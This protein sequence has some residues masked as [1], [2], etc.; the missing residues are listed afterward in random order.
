MSVII[1][2]TGISARGSEPTPAY[3]YE[4]VGLVRLWWRSCASSCVHVMQRSAE[5][6]RSPVVAFFCAS[7]V[8]LPYRIL[9][10]DA[11]WFDLGVFAAGPCVERGVHPRA[12]DAARCWLGE[13]ADGGVFLHG[14]AGMVVALVGDAREGHICS[15]IV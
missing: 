11:D 7:C 15:E 1:I 3:V 2:S 6:W 4:R 5:S 8:F 14:R 9:L 13:D 10:R 12:L